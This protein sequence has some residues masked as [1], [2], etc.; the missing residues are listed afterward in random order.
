ML[1]TF[2]HILQNIVVAQS[3]RKLCSFYE[4]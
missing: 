1:I 2:V 4:T 3:V